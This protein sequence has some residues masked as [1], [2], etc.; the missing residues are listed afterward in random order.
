MKPLTIEDLLATNETLEAV[1]ERCGGF[2]EGHSLAERAAEM[3]MHLALASNIVMDLA[4]WLAQGEDVDDAILKAI[5]GEQ[6]LSPEMQ[7][8]WEEGRRLSRN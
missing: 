1:S 2:H 3:R 4:K 5:S 7:Q 8:A 6:K